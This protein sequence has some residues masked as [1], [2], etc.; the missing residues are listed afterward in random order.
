VA[1]FLKKA[2]EGGDK[3]PR[4][5]KESFLV[6]SNGGPARHPCGGTADPAPAVARN[7]NRWCTTFAMHFSWCNEMQRIPDPACAPAPVKKA[8]RGGEVVLPEW[9]A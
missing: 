2:D 4:K 7:L 9:Q 1:R 6:Q 5:R 3:G 8:G